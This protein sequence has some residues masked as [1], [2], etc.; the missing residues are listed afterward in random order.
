M[1]LKLVC[2]YKWQVDVLVILPDM[3][4]LDQSTVKLRLKPT[5]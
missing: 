4:L 5:S 3:L 1:M 2:L